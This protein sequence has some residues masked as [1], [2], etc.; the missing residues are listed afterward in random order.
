[1]EPRDTTLKLMSKRLE[2][3]A[4]VSKLGCRN[5]Q[6]INRSP[7]VVFKLVIFEGLLRFSLSYVIV[8]QCFL[9]IRKKQAT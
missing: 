1:M 6:L 7:V 5:N 9:S 8:N 4:L 3:T 2:N